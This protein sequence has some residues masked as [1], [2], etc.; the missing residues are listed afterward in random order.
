[1][2]QRTEDAVE[3]NRATPCP[4]NVGLPLLAALGMIHGGDEDSAT[5]LEAKA[6]T[7][8]MVGYARIHLA[9]TIPLAVIRQDR[10][11]VRRLLDSIQP[12]WLTGGAWEQLAAVF[13]ALV[14][15]N[16]RGRIEAEAPPWVRPDSYVAPFAV[17]ALGVARADQTLLDD[18]VHRFEAMGMAWHAEQ[19]RRMLGGA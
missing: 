14:F 17:R 16:D 2:T 11:E 3:A 10:A 13:D 4:F 5:R 6:E 8:G 7:F 15:L 1:M 12:G 19:T 9:R 18:A